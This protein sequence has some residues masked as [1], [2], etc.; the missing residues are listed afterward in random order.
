MLTDLKI[1]KIKPE[2]GKVRKVADSGGLKVFVYPSGTKSFKIGYRYNGKEQTDT[3]GKYPYVSLLQARARR[4]EIKRMLALGLNP[5]L[6]KRKSKEKA[7]A[8]AENTFAILADSY[9]NKLR[10][11]RPQRAP[12]TIKKNIAL[13]AEAKRA[14]G[15]LPMSEVDTRTI[16]KLLEKRIASGHMETAR[17]LRT[18]VGSVF[19]HALSKGIV[20]NRYATS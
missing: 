1:K 9:L 6:E 19:R 15:S 20:N 18:V 17:R 10:M 11:H 7:I 16:A 3:V 12:A 14:F 4:D 5:A 13:L 2:N 8:E